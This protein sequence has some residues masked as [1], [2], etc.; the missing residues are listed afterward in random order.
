MTQP[1]DSLTDPLT[2]LP[3]VL[4][5]LTSLQ[6]NPEVAT[7]VFTAVRKASR[8]AKVHSFI[9]QLLAPLTA[10]SLTASSETVRIDATNT[11]TALVRALISRRFTKVASAYVLDVVSLAKQVVEHHSSTPIP[12]DLPLFSEAASLVADPSRHTQ[13]FQP[14][15]LPRLPVT[16]LTLQSVLHFLALLIPSRLPFPE[17]FPVKQ[18]DSNPSSRKSTTHSEHSSFA[19]P[20]LWIGIG[21]Q[22]RIAVLNLAISNALLSGRC[23]NM[24]ALAATYLLERAFDPTSACIVPL[25]IRRPLCASIQSILQAT[26][27][28]PDD[29]NLLK[30][31]AAL[32][33]LSRLSSPSRCIPAT[34]WAG[35]GI[36]EA[37]DGK[38][39]LGL[40][41]R[42]YS[43]CGMITSYISETRMPNPDLQSLEPPRKRQRIK[44]PA[45][46]S[47]L[48]ERDVS[49]SISQELSS[50]PKRLRIQS[51]YDEKDGSVAISQELSQVPSVD[52]RRKTVS[53]LQKSLQ[54]LENI[55]VCAEKPT[56][57]RLLARACGLT[58]DSLSG[59]IAEKVRCAVS[60]EEWLSFAFSLILIV[61]D[62]LSNIREGV[63]R[64]VWEAVFELTEACLRLA[65]S[66]R[67]LGLLR[68]L[69]KPV[70]K[71]LI[72]NPTSS[73]CS[74]VLNA[75][76]AVLKVAS[77]SLKAS[78][79]NFPVKK[80]SEILWNVGEVAFS[81][82]LEASVK[83]DLTEAC[84]IFQNSAV[85]RDISNISLRAALCRGAFHLSFAC[86]DPS[87]VN[88]AGNVFRDIVD[89]IYS[90]VS[91]SPLLSIAAIYSLGDVVCSKVGCRMK[92]CVNSDYNNGL[93]RCALLNSDIWAT[94]FDMIN[95]LHQTSCNL[96]VITAS[97]YCCGVLAIHGCLENSNLCVP[98]LI[99]AL[100]HET[101]AS[102][103]AIAYSFISLLLVLRAKVTG[104]GAS[105][106]YLSDGLP[107]QVK[108][109]GVDDSCYS[110]ENASTNEGKMDIIT[111][112]FGKEL[113][114][115][116][117]TR[118]MTGLRNNNL[119]KSENID[120]FLLS[121]MLRLKKKE[122]T[123]FKVVGIASD[124]LLTA[125]V[126]EL[127]HE[128]S[129]FS[130]GTNQ[131]SPSLGVAPQ[132]PFLFTIWNYIL[133]AVSIVSGEFYSKYSRLRNIGL[134]CSGNATADQHLLKA[135][136]HAHLS[137]AQT[138]A[139][140]FN[141]QAANWF[142]YT[143]H[144]MLEDESFSDQLSTIL[145]DGNV[146]A[147]WGKVPRHAVGSLLRAG[148]ATAL[149]TLGAKVQRPTRALIEK[150]CADTLA[151]ASMVRKDA[152][153]SKNCFS[154]LILEY[155][156]GPMSDIVSKRA[157]KMVQRLV[158]EFGE[159]K[160]KRAKL[161]LV[162]L[163]RFVN[164]HRPG[165]NSTDEG[166][167]ALVAKHFMLV[168]DAVNRGLF[169]SK[170]KEKD[171]LRYLHVLQVV[172]SLASE[173]LHLFVP[174]IMATLK[175]ALDASQGNESYFFQTLKVWNSFL[176]T[177]GSDRMLA[178]L[179]SILA[180]LLPFFV[181]FEKI[182]A[183]TLIVLLEQVE[184]KP[185]NNRSTIILLLRI[186]GHP[187]L[188][189]TAGR[190]ELQNRAGRAEARQGAVTQ[191]DV[192]RFAL[193]QID[194]LTELCT[195][196]CSIIVHHQNGI[197][198]VL[199]AKYLL[200][201]LQYNR[202]TIDRASGSYSRSEGPENSRLIGTL[203]TLL[204]SLVTQLYKTRNE[205]C[206]E[207]LIQCI[208][209][210]GAL[211]PVIV[212]E[213]C[214]ISLVEEGN[215]SK[216]TSKRFP[217]N[218]HGLVAF[219]LDNF[220]VPILVQG[221]KSH[222]SNSRLNRVGLVI[223]EL[224]RVCGC[225]H[226]TASRASKGVRHRSSTP[227]QVEWKN[228]LVGETAEEN[229]IFFWENL[230][231][232]TRNVVQPYLAEP[233][234]VQQYK[235]VFGGTSAGDVQLVC[236]PVWSKVKEMST[237]GIISSA[238]E[239]RRQMVVQLVDFIGRQGKFGEMLSA[240]RPVLRYEDEVTAFIFPL[241]V[242][243]ALDIQRGKGSI[244]L[245]NHFVQ[246][247][248]EVLKEGTSP[249]PIFDMF[250]TLRCWREERCVG[251]GRNMLNSRV[252]L[253]GYSNTGGSS[254]RK[255]PLAVYVESVKEKDPLTP[256]VDLE[257]REAPP[258][259][260]LI[261]AK[262]AYAARSYCRAIF[263]AEGHIR[264]TRKR[265]GDD[266]W[267]S[268][269]ETVIGKGN[270]ENSGSTGS[271]AEALLILQRAFAEIEDPANMSGIA[272]LRPASS[273]AETAIDNEAA[274]Q[275]DEALITYERAIAEDPRSVQFH[276]GF[277]S[278]LMTLGHW[279]T[280]LSHSEGLVSSSRLNELE[281][282]QTA[283][284]H[285]I[286]A[287]W[288]LGR[289][290][291]V[292]DLGRHSSEVSRNILH[293]QSVA[294]WTLGFSISFGKMLT[295]LHAGDVGALKAAASEGRKTLLLPT[296][297]A[298]REGYNRVYPMIV[299]L[300][301]LA[302]V[303]DALES[304]NMRAAD[305][306]GA[307]GGIQQ[308]SGSCSLKALIGLK[309]R[310]KATASSLNIR[311]PILSAKRVCYEL[312]NLPIDAAR[313]NLE[314]AKL[315]REG[316]NLRAA[317]A[318]AFRA[319]SSTS[320]DDE[321][322]N[323]SVMEMAHIRRAQGEAS[324]ALV[325]V[326]K[327]IDRLSLLL[328]KQQKDGGRMGSKAVLVSDRL[329]TAYT[330]AGRWIE[331]TRSEPSD[332][333]L[334][335]FE[336][337]CL[338]GPSCEEPFYALGRHYDSLLQ[339][340]ANTEAQA[341][342]DSDMRS[343]RSS[344]RSTIGN[345]NHGN[346]HHSQYVPLVIKSFAN[347]L[348]NGNSRV[349][350][351][352]PRMLTV[353]FDYYTS[354]DDANMTALYSNV[355]SEVRREIKKAFESIPP[356]M[357]MTAI[358]QLMSRIL[359]P[360]KQVRD[361][362]T[363][364]LAK[365]VCTFPD[366]SFWTILPSSQLKSTGRKAAT[367]DILNHSVMITKKA[368]TADSREKTRVLKARIMGALSVVQS[369]VEICGTL[370][371]KDRRGRRENCSKEFK[372]LRTHL[373]SSSV[374]NPI[375]PTLNSLTVRLSRMEGGEHRAFDAEPV[376]I[377]DIEDHVLVM[378]SLM[379]PRRIGLIGSDGRQYRYLAKKEN[380]GDMRKDSRL[381]E[382]ITVVNRLLSKDSVSRDKKLELKTYAV[383][384]LSEETGMI[385]WV[386]DLCALRTVIRDEHYGYANL[387]DTSMIQAK[388]QSMRD[389]R[390]FLEDW[391]FIK[392]PCVLHRFFVRG[393]GGGSDAQAWLSARN[394]WTESTGGWSMAGYIVGLGD[395][396]GEN[397]LIETTTGRCVHVDF[398]MLF[399]KG[400]K[401]KVPE[402][403]PF[404]LTRNMV[405]AMGVAGYEGV[406]R[407]VCELVMGIM[408]RNSDALLGVL[409]SFLH[410]PLADWGRSDTRG[411]KG[412][413]IASKEA[414]QMQT[415][416]KAK[417]TGMVDGSGL[418]LSI[419][420]QVQRLIH[421]ASSLDNLSRMYLW[422]SAW[423]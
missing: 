87:C 199:A 115:R 196:V 271:E 210:V 354:L 12:F 117:S 355:E 124:S 84:Q 132:A 278:C 396:H 363:H 7:S 53:G 2:L 326:R 55:Y 261:Q 1:Q 391:A 47:S 235:A 220:L 110:I 74:A 410:D 151:R 339:A 197:I 86:S 380:Q 241:A 332:V 381:V 91:S 412:G 180:I 336:Q 379:R 51:S 185:F 79:N 357:W 358:P 340:G 254:K 276:K 66:L 123:L 177:L 178:H 259:S 405:S 158:M 131:G 315:G 73:S 179:G 387:P 20:K 257:G 60:L 402:I 226:D 280:M 331:E 167:G 356:Y 409:E 203:A 100:G 52:E 130:G 218:V 153:D 222:N 236:Q 58:A 365:I 242:T 374:A 40:M 90:N 284:A 82:G 324:R 80:L 94:V 335:Y 300:H 302:D 127:L 239:W 341:G 67:S 322:M 152:F 201:M 68:S 384:P 378:S 71:V 422:W 345:M 305:N 301:S 225:K 388:Y 135:R 273:L 128:F 134:V 217:I 389:H 99:Q 408:R 8:N 303:E 181:D 121:L 6:N 116:V 42:S 359:H 200:K 272:A 195:N 256:L 286:A 368:K 248:S 11:C 212:S 348:S 149:E 39:S 376:R 377:G 414:W 103:R 281:L 207:K 89:T 325:M 310:I 362:L 347:T 28:P 140:F 75:I 293:S 145:T 159:Y 14:A 372:E 57:M 63:V 78:P 174:K 258:I 144:R 139:N 382:F 234:D 213:F 194:Q 157:G 13:P 296:I 252:T 227:D 249:Q 4:Q 283:Q 223:Q 81:N 216:H 61:R 330:V 34:T 360:R 419:K 164:R 306:S 253:P 221:E 43:R 228:I 122:V 343:G 318:S 321:V 126:S 56:S 143:V 361:D 198:E 136:G 190:L 395:R 83:E 255:T 327:E 353:W 85:S 282:R 366:E 309:A 41:L 423:I 37:A 16:S 208:G 397:V 250:D 264:N 292:E 182:L 214:K 31:R 299:L 59:L 154:N 392:F 369:F 265:R 398:A 328:E 413:I 313:V 155:L 351:A 119:E 407:G 25:V 23:G 371:P 421:D 173:H 17:T 93:E 270:H 10:V 62:V 206:Q 287:A 101:S 352:L 275:Y 107:L 27:P 175:M 106:E 162:Y 406:Y 323:A 150:V 277:L 262:S 187:L 349:F 229:S 148:S 169:H 383:L 50:S 334:S 96:E 98:I 245:Q 72:S 307:G 65:S 370:L 232:T 3:T 163:S 45:A 137:L 364:L 156:G 9:V 237:T 251:R 298:A 244:E 373:K 312:L 146:K 418:T 26:Y 238:R 338:F 125:A 165:V 54:S 168:M 403:V 189:K 129:K 24:V 233:F 399:D 401:L 202:E 191:G 33:R 171:C 186:V 211:D 142:P 230:L 188:D 288:R 108:P 411:A 111:A 417:L 294:N 247:I 393:F 133:M 290:D 105:E 267:A 205:D 161:G 113:L 204:E 193:L 224:L 183:P 219:L 350:E 333:I 18:N 21:V 243:T 109:C 118:N 114:H 69:T 266:G 176:K 46:H 209:E 35:C 172:I 38:G 5:H 29:E 268:F 166:V 88:G 342:M 367:A 184:E 231:S 375:I 316:E 104:L 320:I 44:P 77:R 95:S 260:L 400:L 138:T 285:G 337:A 70:D 76:G 317:S 291:K 385:E 36:R 311:E 295:S 92:H 246:E 22:S 97:T 390:K 346:D 289:W 192:S 304:F 160:E 120:A 263:L 404:R 19:S 170:A 308:Q 147:L 420:G 344:R 32:Y 102:V 141:A 269:M 329:C 215:V 30:V 319:L 48:D 297:R 240:L 386:N 279:E 314:L 49:V 415:A 64:H 274:G 112:S 15:T 394:T 416:V